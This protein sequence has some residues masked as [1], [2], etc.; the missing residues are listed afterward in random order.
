MD[1]TDN[2]VDEVAVIMAIGDNIKSQSNYTQYTRNNF[3]NN[4]NNNNNDGDDD[5]QDNNDK[6]NYHDD[7]IINDVNNY[8]N[9]NYLDLKGNDDINEKDN[10]D[11]KNIDEDGDDD[12]GDDDDN[13]DDF[14]PVSQIRS[15]SSRSTKQTRQLSTQLP[16]NS[17]YTNRFK[18]S[19]TQPDYHQST[20]E[21]DGIDKYTQQRLRKDD[22]S[23][24][25]SSS[26][27]AEI[28]KSL[29]TTTIAAT[30][31]TSTTIAAQKNNT[32]SQSKL[33]KSRNS[34]N[35]KHLS[36]D[37]HQQKYHSDHLSSQQNQFQQDKSQ[38]SHLQQQPQQQ[39]RQRQQQADRLVLSP[40]P[41]DN[42]LKFT[43]NSKLTSPFKRTK[44][45]Q[46]PTDDDDKNNYIYDNNVSI[47]DPSL[48][49]KTIGT[50]STSSSS[51]TTSNNQ[52]KLKSSL[53]SLP[54][55]TINETLSYVHDRLH[56]YVR[57]PLQSSLLP[58]S[59]L[60]PSSQV[61]PQRQSSASLASPPSYLSDKL[62]IQQTKE[63][64]THNLP[65][66][67]SSMNDSMVKNPKNS[68]SLNNKI[69]D[70]NDD[71]DYN[72]R[73]KLSPQNS[74]YRTTF[75]NSSIN[76]YYRDDAKNGSDQ[77]SI[78]AYDEKKNGYDSVVDL[79]DDA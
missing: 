14:I 79:T 52:N 7:D 22:S 27:R 34:V 2:A 72:T 1:Q 71:H 40:I 36:H 73:I 68:S 46:S 13:D 60:Q 4:N 49:A 57:N 58:P 17:K 39:Q 41:T 53:T 65:N 50:T 45:N 75:R 32:K 48:T 25:S 6:M 35:S 54:L 21:S 15:Q 43:Y 42:I 9:Y 3:T 70:Y 66:S 19:S 12:D 11:K 26:S 28:K 10:D 23:N 63:L 18:V 74:N 47:I 24:S 69:D 30:T 20:Q 59:L 64:G 51:T 33:Q 61:E 44:L 67:S 56:P 5:D 78:G 77:S 16:A 62:N 29:T 8:D 31:T 38:A 76:N 55:Q 37:Q